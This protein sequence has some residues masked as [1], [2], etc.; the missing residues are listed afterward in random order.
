MVKLRLYVGD[1]DEDQYG[2][3]KSRL[4]EKL[5]NGEEDYEILNEE[6]GISVTPLTGDLPYL[7]VINSTLEKPHSV[8]DQEG[9]DEILQ[10]LNTTNLD[11]AYE[12][13]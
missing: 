12:K 9:V 7:S 3:V 4:D 11:T 8:S 5:E 10:C 2:E 6:P 13:R 1:L